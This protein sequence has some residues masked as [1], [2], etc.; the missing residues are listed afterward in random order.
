MSLDVHPGHTKE[1]AARSFPEV[2]IQYE[3]Y[4]RV[5]GRN[6]GVTSSGILARI[7]RDY[8]ADVIVTCEEVRT[9]VNELR[10]LPTDNIVLELLHLCER[11]LARGLNVY[12]FAD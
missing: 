11:A 9:L 1:E 5:F 12:F 6:A 3:D 2:S 4:E 8:D 10:R 7:A